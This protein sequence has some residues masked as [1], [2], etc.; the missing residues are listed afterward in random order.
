M[1]GQIADISFPVIR[2]RTRTIAPNIH[3][4]IHPSIPIPDSLRETLPS[5]ESYTFAVI[6]NELI[7]RLEA[8]PPPKHI[9]ISLTTHTSIHTA[10]LTP[11]PSI[12]QIEE[13]HP[14]Q[15]PHLRIQRRR[16]AL[17]DITPQPLPPPPPFSLHPQLLPQK[18]H[19]LRELRPAADLE[20]VSLQH[21]RVPDALE[22]DCDFVVRGRRGGGQCE[23]HG[24]IGREGGQEERGGEG[25]GEWGVIGG[26]VGCGG[27]DG[28]GVGG[29]GGGHRFEAY[30]GGRQVLSVVGELIGHK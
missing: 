28:G 6:N 18:H 20:R 15:P 1:R 24:G 29:G 16:K 27:G 2:L 26:V 30:E 9:N 7:I 5:A 14:P 25:H 12:L 3:P 23:C 4:F 21:R 11:F 13:T 10:H 19:H 22:H 8:L 17:I